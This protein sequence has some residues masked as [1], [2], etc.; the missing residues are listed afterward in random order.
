MLR[1]WLVRFPAMKFTESVRSRQVPPTPGTCVWPPR[2]PSVPTSRATR[3]TSSANAESWSTIVLRVP[4]SSSIS[5]P[6]DP[7]H[8][9][10]AA[11]AAFG[12]HL[13]GH[14]GHLVGERRE[15]VDHRVKG[16][17][18]LEHL[19]L[20]VHGDFLAEITPGDRRR[21]LRD[22]ADLTGEVSRHG[23]H[24]VGQVLPRPRNARH[25][26]LAAELPVGA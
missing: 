22:V 2:R 15:L 1:T 17:L 19:A 25:L 5:D 4:F 8:L 18:Q 6:A 26:R 14:P 20:D 21:D 7:W 16:A 11:Q 23:V 12:T 3:V 9:R 24:R 13:A 10:L